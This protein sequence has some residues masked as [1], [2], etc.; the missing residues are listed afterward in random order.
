MHRDHEMTRELEIS[1]YQES[2]YVI[3]MYKVLMYYLADTLLAC[4][5]IINI[6]LFYVHKW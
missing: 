6:S 2:L 4:Y 3:Q 1:V 5:V